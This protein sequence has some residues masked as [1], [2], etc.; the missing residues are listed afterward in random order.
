MEFDAKRATASVTTSDTSEDRAAS[1]AQLSVHNIS[2][3]GH[4]SARLPMFRTPSPESR[5]QEPQSPAEAAP[6]LT[7]L[8]PAPRHHRAVLAPSSP[9][10]LPSNRTRLTAIDT[11]TYAL[12]RGYNGTQ[13]KSPDTLLLAPTLPTPV[14]PASPTHDSIYTTPWAATRSEAEERMGL[15]PRTAAEGP[16]LAPPSPNPYVVSWL[17]RT[18]AYHGAARSEQDEGSPVESSSRYLL[19]DNVT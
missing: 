6:V 17:R 18:A 3:D 12:A 14:S 19:P 5:V 4:P 8:S 15:K 2:V 13:T 10:P 16:T 9:S 11:T 1:P 7:S